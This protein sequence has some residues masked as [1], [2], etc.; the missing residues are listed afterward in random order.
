MY[1]DD[2]YG[3][4]CWP[5]LVKGSE[6]FRTFCLIASTKKQYLA[7]G[8]QQCCCTRM[9]VYMESKLQQ[10]WQASPPNWLY[11]WYIPALYLEISNFSMYL[12][13]GVLVLHRNVVEYVRFTLYALHSISHIYIPGMF[14]LWDT[15]WKDFYGLPGIKYLNRM[16]WFR[17]HVSFFGTAAI[18]HYLVQQ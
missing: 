5:F 4:V 17:F 16:V 14:F 10:Q 15:A 13:T 8:T 3:L 11:M 9:S 18:Q 1:T 2:E 6:A 7:P 12:C